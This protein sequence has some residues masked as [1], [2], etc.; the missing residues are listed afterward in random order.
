MDKLDLIPIPEKDVSKILT[1]LNKQIPFR[2]EEISGLR[3]KTGVG[4]G[5]ILKIEF[6]EEGQ[7]P[8]FLEGEI[9]KIGKEHM[10][11]AVEV[12]KGPEEHI[13]AL[14]NNPDNNKVQFFNQKIM[15]IIFTYVETGKIEMTYSGGGASRRVAKGKKRTTHKRKRSYKRQRV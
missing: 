8:V 4:R 11:R 15:N 3:Y 14:F 12:K 2:T 6:K 13:D 10:I 1:T 9:V 7:I 5:M